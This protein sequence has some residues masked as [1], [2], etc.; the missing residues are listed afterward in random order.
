MW[1]NPLMLTGLVALA[2]PVAIHLVMRARPRRMVFPALRFVRDSQRA[3]GG[4]NRLKHLL[5]LALRVAVLALLVVILA[6]PMS[7]RHVVSAAAELDK[8]PASVVLCFDN[9]PSMTYRFQ[10]SSRL[11]E[12]QRLARRIVERMPADSRFAVLDLAAAGPARWLDT[13]AGAV[14]QAIGRVAP[15]HLSSNVGGLLTAAQLLLKEGGDKPRPD[16]YLFT[17]MTAAAW[18]GIAPAAFADYDQVPVYV[19][20]V[21]VEENLNAALNLPELSSRL[22]ARN[23]TV[24]ISDTVANGARPSSRTVAL[25]LSGQVRGRVP[26]DLPQ[27]G[28]TAA[29]RFN[30]RMTDEGLVQGRL[31]LMES[32]PVAADNVRYFSLRVGRPPP[33]A[34]VHGSAGAG[35]G[36]AA[37]LV[38]QALA[39]EELLL[40]GQATVRPE[41]L[42]V[43]ALGKQPLGEFEAVFLVDA[44]G[45]SDAG[46]A[47]LD[48]FVA[49]GGGLVVLMGQEVADELARGS[50]SYASPAARGL[51][52]A[53][54]GPLRQLGVATRFTVPSYETPVLAAFDRG[55]TADLGR[56]EI[57]RYVE[58][59]PAAG[60][61]T[62]LGLATGDAALLAGTARGGSVFTLATGP[63]REW[64]NLA[65][66]PEEFVVLMHSLLGA[67][68]GE[69]APPAE[70]AIG[71][72]ISFSF[73]RQYA[74]R[75]VTLTGPGLATPDGRQINATTAVAVL[76][77]LFEP[78][79]YLLRVAAAGGS[80]VFGF[81]LNVDPAESRPGRRSAAEIEKLFARGRV[82]LATDLDSLQ[83]AETLVRQGRE[84]TAFFLPLL[85]AAMIA[86]LLLANRFY[87]RP[88]G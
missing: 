51:L 27:P 86:E 16:I 62:I 7:R 82:H 79:N 70:F 69:F 14:E 34:I 3:S 59:K 61:K 56:T 83:Q 71:Q 53:E 36:A 87:R 24:R 72:P 47:A 41:A 39:P 2:I 55:Q 77:P 44:A 66:R 29:V 23:S 88:A 65:A 12:A 32:D 30:E 4:V 17:D 35:Q 11:D 15:C 84:L 57:G 8:I 67:A 48:R 64:S 68:R 74:G 46:W 33:V 5:L 26:V 6:R 80:E 76:P 9:S 54:V 52:G 28:T 25:E 10:G 38:A 75:S 1:L 78:G 37:L 49:G 43:A 31:M 58:L 45:I 20:D 42:P 18:D 73:P 63:A 22:A 21:G 40:A 81:S 85:M 50:S 13:D 60:T 19:L